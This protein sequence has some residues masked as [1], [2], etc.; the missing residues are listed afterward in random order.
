MSNAAV[1]WYDANIAQLSPF[2]ESLDAGSLHTWFGDLLPP[3][4]AVIVDIGAG[5]GRD[6]AHFAAA[7]YDVV[8]IEPSASMRA[9]GARL[10]RHPRLRWLSD[11]LPGLQ[12]ALKAGITADVVLANAVWQHVVPADRARSFRKM[13][14]L[15][16]PGG[17]LTLT[18]RVGA[19]DGRGAF[20][21]G[22]DE[23][24]RLARDH[25]MQVVRRVEASDAMGRPGVRWINL[26]LRLPDDGTGALPLLRH[27][28][29][30]QE[31]SS[32]YKLG[33][34]RALCR[35]ADGAAGLAEEDGEGH[36]VIPLGL[37]ALN[38]L[39]LYL[40]LASANLPQSPR[41][42]SGA[43]TLGFA[44]P[45][46]RALAAGAAT[47]RDL[48]VGAAFGPGSGP[49]VWSALREAADLIRRMPAFHL[50]RAD[51][52]PIFP[53]TRTR[54]A[55]RA[56]FVLDGPALLA[57]GTMRVPLDVWRAMS[58]YA[59]W[60]EPALVAEWVRLMQGYAAGQGRALDQTAMVAATTWA[61]PDRGVGVPRAIAIRKFSEGHHLH[62]VWSG[63]RLD[64]RSL[65]M[66]HCLPWAAWPCGD[67]WNIAPADRR[68]NQ[69]AKRGLLPSADAL[70][71]A[72]GP[73]AA[74]WSEAYL[75]LGDAVLPT[76]FAAEARSSLPGLGS[77]SRRADTSDVLAAVSLQRLR[78]RHDQG[79]PEWTGG[80]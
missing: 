23:V 65:D 58:R 41:N 28:I 42:R 36:V 5:T 40:P 75:S 54:S 53:A 35:A 66:D 52:S 3:A 14:T 32:T 21:V 77:G 64:E 1:A 25:G 11:S 12:A 7:G 22:A 47:A 10:H 70:D 63:K 29:L 45:G 2:Y 67:L 74:W 39:R 56:T 30:L 6:G 69:H 26:A 80:R 4:P 51:G 34:L 68:L 19:D 71:A 73:I 62:C 18:L 60:I 8:A 72:S 46:W 17:L 57:L 20:P 16:R 61:D 15:L 43:D 38:W 79:V 24:E 76:R 13:V 55:E 37:V 78:L 9:E 49:A 48:R 59:A 44:G 27:V 50:T 31:K 33:L